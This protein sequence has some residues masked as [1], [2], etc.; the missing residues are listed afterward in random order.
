MVTTVFFPNYNMMIPQTVVPIASAQNPLTTGHSTSAK[1][2]FDPATGQP[3]S[4]SAPGGAVPEVSREEQ[5]YLN[6]AQ[7]RGFRRE[8]PKT[9]AEAGEPM[10]LR[11]SDGVPVACKYCQANPCHGISWVFEGEMRFK[12]DACGRKQKLGYL[13]DV[14]QK[15][16]AEL[17][18]M[19]RAETNRR[20]IW[21]EDDVQREEERKR[22]MDEI[23]TNP[24]NPY[25]GAMTN[26]G[27]VDSTFFS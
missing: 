21:R 22:Q 25:Y 10:T 26:R 6:V 13:A 8:Q 2:G 3:L 18:G 1:D 15:T 7:G 20:R 19:K 9:E 16:S 23:A 14:A 4:S 11:G 12:C 24:D 27:F 17:E 5:K